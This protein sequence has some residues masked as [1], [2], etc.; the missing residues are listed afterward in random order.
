[1]FNYDAGW[2]VVAIHA[3][4]VVLESIATCFI[5]R[6]FFDNVIG[7]E[8]IVQAR[9][10]EL[11][12][13]TRDMRMLLDN[14]Q[15]GFVT[16]DRAG[17]LQAERLGSDRRVVRGANGG[18]SWF[19]YLHI[20]SPALGL[21]SR[22]AWTE[23]TAASCRSRSRSSRCRAGCAVGDAHYSF[24]YRPIG[25][26]PCSHFLVIVTDVTEHVRSERASEERREVLAVFERALADRAGLESFIEDATN[27][28]TQLS[29]GATTDFVLVK[30]LLHTVKGNS[31]LYGLVTIARR[32][33]D[34]EDAIAET[35][36]VPTT[37]AYVELA[38]RW[39]TVVS[40]VTMLLGEHLRGIEIDEAQYAKLESVARSGDAAAMVR[41]VRRIRLEPT[42]KRFSHFAE[43]ARRIAAR[44][45]KVIDVVIEDH[46]VRLEPKVWGPFWSA[47]V[48]GVRNAVDHGIEPEA[49][50][51]GKPAI[52]QLTLRSRDDGEHFIVEIE[53]DGRG[54][55]WDA[56]RRSARASGVPCDSDRELE[57]ALFVDGLST[58]TH[59][60]DLS[61]RGVGLCAL[62]DST[63]ALGGEISIVSQLGK[64]TVVRMKFPKAL[65]FGER[66]MALA[67]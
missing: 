29:T 56:V 22:V 63:R 41:E 40:E 48:H 32:C 66:S 57:A 34:L 64:G 28:V 59:V 11:D 15:Q 46:D 36:A 30:R 16:I 54:I 10:A 23:V 67:S 47:F 12:Q 6:S 45:D 38:A 7:L 60:S 55:D 49:E 50:R 43:Q 19:D 44:L 13:R 24:D 58:T 37:A 53:D 3:A 9:T 31:S 20:Q 26:E 51:T 21:A 27:M 8:R 52:G 1:M 33:H 14:V 35:G 39:Q 18:Q 61:G 42:A 2:W 65:A 62:R 17:V 4:F 25:A 5:A